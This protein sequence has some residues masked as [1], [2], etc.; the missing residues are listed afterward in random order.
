M[1][2][3]GVEVSDQVQRPGESNDEFWARLEQQDSA[4]DL[5]STQHYLENFALLG[6]VKE[7]RHGHFAV[8]QA[9]WCFDWNSIFDSH[10]IEN[11]FALASSTTCEEFYAFLQEQTGL[12]LARWEPVKV[13]LFR[14]WEI[15][16]RDFVATEFF[17]SLHWSGTPGASAPDRLSGAIDVIGLRHTSWRGGQR[18]VG[19]YAFDDFLCARVK[20]EAFETWS[21]AGAQGEFNPSALQNYDVPGYCVWGALPG[22]VGRPILT[23][24]TARIEP[25]LLAAQR[26]KSQGGTELS[27]SQHG[28]LAYG[29]EGTTN[30]WAA[31]VRDEK[32][33]EKNGSGPRCFSD[34]YFPNDPE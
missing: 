2:N 1:L 20:D 7:G 9:Q 18:E 17:A 13:T 25:Q 31:L 30:R 24:P 5:A 21:R 27:I 16:D 34:L 33:R 14:K 8:L 12:E 29:V 3:T 22:E 15:A 23:W 11:F 32:L 19:D 4:K 10:G 6:R 28:G 26:F